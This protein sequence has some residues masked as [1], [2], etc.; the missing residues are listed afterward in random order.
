MVA[1]AVRDQDQVDLAELVEIFVL[2]RRLGIPGEPGI[3][4][5]HLAAGRG[6]LEGGLGE[7][8]QLR[9]ALRVGAAGEQQANNGNESKYAG[10]HSQLPNYW[11]ETSMISAGVV[12]HLRVDVRGGL[13]SIYFCTY[14]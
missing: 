10:D 6:E 1:V 11:V 9:L 7:P 5:D 4:H 12:S 13:A 8:L 2:R 3:D 14:I